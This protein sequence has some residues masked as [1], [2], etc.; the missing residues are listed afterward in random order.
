M[1]DILRIGPNSLPHDQNMEHTV[2][3]VCAAAELG[4]HHAAHAKK[5][6]STKTSSPTESASPA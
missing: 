1:I 4:E 5:T 2:P 3:L 6:A